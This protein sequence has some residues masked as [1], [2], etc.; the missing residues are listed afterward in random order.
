MSG[1][2]RQLQAMFEGR[3]GGD[4]TTSPSTTERTL[5]NWAQVAAQWGG[6]FP[7]PGSHVCFAAA[8]VVLFP[9]YIYRPQP[10]GSK[11]YE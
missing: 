3:H 11:L 9:V 10:T 1:R 2:E 4:I 8:P 5:V 7:L 6:G